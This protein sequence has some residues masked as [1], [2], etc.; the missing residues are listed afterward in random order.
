M[1]GLQHNRCNFDMLNI[2]ADLRVWHLALMPEQEGSCMQLC[3]T[4]ATASMCF[5]TILF[6]TAPGCL[7]SADDDRLAARR[8]RG[9]L[10][11][12]PELLAAG[13]ITETTGLLNVIKTLVRA[14]LK[15]C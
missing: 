1:I 10:R 11:L 9:A 13:I 14:G 15:M 5:K 6:S 8:Q 7:T 2:A 4:I 3:L 12:L